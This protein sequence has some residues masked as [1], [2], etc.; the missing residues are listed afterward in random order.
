MNLR[1]I[2]KLYLCAQ[3][4]AHFEA[5]EMAIPVEIDKGKSKL[6][7]QKFPALQLPMG[8]SNVDVPD[9]AVHIAHS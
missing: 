1:D 7:C 6:S 8:D 3:L 9:S 2:S 4:K 5:L